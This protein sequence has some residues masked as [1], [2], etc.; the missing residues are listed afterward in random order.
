MAGLAEAALSGVLV[1]SKKSMIGEIIFDWLA[2]FLF[3]IF[4]RLKS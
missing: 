3:T 2:V 1:T 4:R